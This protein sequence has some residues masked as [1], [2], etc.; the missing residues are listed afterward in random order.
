MKILFACHDPPAPIT[1][2][3]VIDMLGMV[4]ALHDLG[5]ELYNAN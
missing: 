2:G 5:H 3:G 1:N 4:Q